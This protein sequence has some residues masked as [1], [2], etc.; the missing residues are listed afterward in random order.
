MQTRLYIK[1]RGDKEYFKERM[2]DRWMINPEWVEWLMGFP[3]NWTTMRRARSKTIEDSC[4]DPIIQAQID[5]QE[6]SLL[7]SQSPAADGTC[8]EFMIPSFAIHSAKLNYLH[9]DFFPISLLD[10]IFCKSRE[11]PSAFFAIGQPPSSST[12]ENMSVNRHGLDTKPKL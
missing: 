6:K 1:Q 4:D 8:R 12:S 2:D 5:M 9:M 10:T 3:K 11:T 7:K